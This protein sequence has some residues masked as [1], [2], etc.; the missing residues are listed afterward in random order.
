MDRPATRLATLAANKASPDPETQ[1]V[2]Q[3]HD[4]LNVSLQKV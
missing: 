4:V 2:I 3:G 1:G